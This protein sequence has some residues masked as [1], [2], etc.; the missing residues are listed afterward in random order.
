[1]AKSKKASKLVKTDKTAMTEQ[2]SEL[3]A[4]NKLSDWEANFVN[5]MQGIV[6]ERDLSSREHQKIREIAEQRLREE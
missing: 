4:S 1:V 3:L 2:L 6:Q 5:S